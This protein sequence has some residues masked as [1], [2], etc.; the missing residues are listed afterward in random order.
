VTRSGDPTSAAYFYGYIYTISFTG[1][2][3]E[4]VGLP[5][6]TAST[7]ATVTAYYNTPQ[8]GSA[9]GGA[10]GYTALAPATAYTVR[11]SARN[12]H[13]YGPAS[14]GT[15]AVTEAVGVLPWTPTAVTLGDC[16]YTRDSLGVEWQPPS[17]GGGQRVDGY[18][19]QWDKTLQFSNANSAFG[20]DYI[21]IVH[22]VQDVSLQCTLPLLLLLCASL[23]VHWYYCE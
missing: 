15:A 3:N 19:V 10:T 7:V 23:A 1:T 14:T 17:R 4:Q 11:A 21:G 2:Y 20:T 18:T 8:H 5:A 16:A 22:E 6:V 13:G 9:R 12:A